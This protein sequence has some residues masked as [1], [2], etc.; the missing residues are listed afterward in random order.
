MFINDTT[1]CHHKNMAYYSGKERLQVFLLQ[2]YVID[3]CV[4]GSHACWH[5][6]WIHQGTCSCLLCL[7][8]SLMQTAIDSSIGMIILSVCLSVH[9]LHCALW[10]NPT[11][12]VSEQV[13]RKC[14]LPPRNTILQLSTPCTDPEPSNCCSWT[15][16]IG[17]IWQIKTQ[18]NRQNFH[19]WNSHHEHAAW[20]LHTTPYNWHDPCLIASFV[21]F[22]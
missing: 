1:C 3:V 8:Q 21:K 22:T 10:L 15:I 17:A 7:G 6:R 16:N 18:V 20:L 4:L 12:K 13:N 9:L 14:L 11:A 5:L 19:I 2:L